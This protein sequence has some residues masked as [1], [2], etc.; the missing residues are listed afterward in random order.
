VKAGV[1]GLLL[2]YFGG[3]WLMVATLGQMTRCRP[4]HHCSQLPE[5]PWTE[6]VR[7]LVSG[8]AG[9][10]AVSWPWHLLWIGFGA[11][12]LYWGL[13]VRRRRLKRAP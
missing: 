10:Y 7:D 3:L 1:T 2:A 8:I 4:E 11:G 12:C 13:V 9:A 6:A 5:V